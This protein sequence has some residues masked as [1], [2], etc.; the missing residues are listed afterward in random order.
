MFI[1]SS[2]LELLKQ[3]AK[4]QIFTASGFNILNFN[5]LLYG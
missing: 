5:I 1:Y 2:T 3:N 4:E